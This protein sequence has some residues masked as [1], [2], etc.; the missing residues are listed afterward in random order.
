MIET[1]ILTPP[2]IN[3]KEVLRYM[4]TT[5]S[6]AVGALIQ[7]CTEECKDIFTYKAC[8]AIYPIQNTPS[9]VALGGKLF[10]GETLQA[11]L[12]GCREVVLLAATVGLGIDRLITKYGRI[13]PSRALC[14]Q[15][16]G[17]E[18][19]EAL[20]DEAERRLLSLLPPGEQLRPRFSPGYGDLPLSAQE[21]VFSLLHPEGRIGLYLGTS[22]LMSPTKSVTAVLGI[23][24]PAGTRKEESI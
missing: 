7:D 22:L 8:F 24:P 6:D 20:C 16:I 13:T 21:A 3:E 1:L 11:H 23:L 18:R 10:A 2:P 9:G 19:I 12:A 4:R 17:T 14:L 15:A 5:A